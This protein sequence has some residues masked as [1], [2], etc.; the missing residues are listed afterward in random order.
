[1]YDFAVRVISLCKQYA[2]NNQTSGW[3]KLPDIPHRYEELKQWF[4][5]LKERIK[6]KQELS[7]EN[8]EIRKIL[9][10]YFEEDKK[11]RWRWLVL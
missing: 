11:K 10:K 9:I 6:P 1:M 8:E 5:S 3:N 4:K 2:I 7:Q